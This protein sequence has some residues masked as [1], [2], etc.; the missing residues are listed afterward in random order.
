MK[1]TILII[2]LITVSNCLAAQNYLTEDA[3]W[4]QLVY[5]EGAPLHVK[6]SI[7]ADTLIGNNTY[8]KISTNPTSYGYNY[9]FYLRESSGVFYQY[10]PSGDRALYDF[11]L[12]VGDTVPSLLSNEHITITHIDTVYLGNTPRKRF[13][14]DNYQGQDFGSSSYL[15]EGI[16]SSAG[17]LELPF[18]GMLF[19]YAAHLLCFSQGGQYISVDLDAFSENIQMESG[20]SNL[21]DIDQPN[22]VEF[23]F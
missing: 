6:H 18:N 16:G 4:H 22:A 5:I 2:L 21:V 12:S 19:D 8:Y 1:N 9:Y 17:L 20:C 13:F 23:Q 3:V 7:E 14:L 11:N 15:I 10:S